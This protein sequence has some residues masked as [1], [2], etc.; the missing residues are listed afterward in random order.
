[1]RTNRHWRMLAAG[2][3]LAGASLAGASLAGLT[4]CS[5]GAAH[6]TPSPGRPGS[7]CG[8]T[9]TGAN[10]PV[11]IKVSKGTV[12]C[13]TALRVENGYATLIKGGKV[14]GNG[15]G[16]PVSV[17]GWTCQG[18]PTS[19]VLRTGD[20]S[21]CHTATAEVVAVVSLPSSGS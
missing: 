1:M 8:T 6:A 19:Q 5:S 3:S 4:A 13:G 12:N 20:A 10:V 11:V 17:N 9:R 21:E 16:A 7:S 18:Y 15:G 2:A 14:P